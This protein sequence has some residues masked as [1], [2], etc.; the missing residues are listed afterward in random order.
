MNKINFSRTKIN[1]QVSGTEKS[2]CNEFHEI[3]QCSTSSTNKN[4]HA[5]SSKNKNQLHEEK[6][7][8]NFHEQNQFQE[9]KNECTTGF[10]NQNQRRTSFT[11]KISMQKVP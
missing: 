8:T 4:K 2:I 6:T 11:N 10:T 7:C 5:K 3:N 1:V 9:D